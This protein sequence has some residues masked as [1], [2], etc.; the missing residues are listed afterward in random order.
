MLKRTPSLWTI[1]PLKSHFSLLK[2]MFGI[3]CYWKKIHRCFVKRPLKLAFYT[4]IGMRPPRVHGAV[5]RRPVVSGDDQ[6]AGQ[7]SEP[8]VVAVAVARWKY[9]DI[10][11]AHLDTNGPTQMASLSILMY[12]AIHSHRELII[13]TS[14]Q[15]GCKG[16]TSNTMLLLVCLV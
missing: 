7:L 1:L 6:V 8:N 14:N 16:W 10:G 15:I 11:G 3:I 5:A 12:F 4:A 9:G 13:L 2:S